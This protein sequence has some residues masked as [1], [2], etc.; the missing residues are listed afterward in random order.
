[1]NRDLSFTTEVERDMYEK[2]IA[3]IDLLELWDW[4][5]TVVLERGFSSLIDPNMG[6]IFNEIENQGYYGHSGS[7]YCI[8]MNDMR[9][10][11]IEGFDVW[12]QQYIL[13]T[14]PIV[15]ILQQ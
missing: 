15:S 1:M 2:T 5:R 11:A 4:L 8:V 6:R 10:I 13:N 12:K 7:S 3:A 14:P 9:T